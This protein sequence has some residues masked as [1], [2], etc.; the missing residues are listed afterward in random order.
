[1]LTREQLRIHAPAGACVVVA[2]TSVLYL[3]APLPVLLCRIRPRALFLYLPTGEQQLYT[4]CP[5]KA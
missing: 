5:W 1:M 3:P 2:P 4:C